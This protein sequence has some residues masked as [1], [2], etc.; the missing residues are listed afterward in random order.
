MKVAI[1]AD[2][3]DNFVK[4]RAEGLNRMLSS[5][6]IPSKVFYQGLQFLDM[7][8]KK[9]EWNLSGPKAALR[10]LIGQVRRP[11]KAFLNRTWRELEN[12]DLMVVVETVPTAFLTYQ[13][14]RVE[15]VRLR[16]PKMP[17][18]LYSSIYLSTM[19][20]WIRFLKHGNDYHGFIKG[21]NHFGLERF[22]WYLIGS[23]ATDFPLP[24]GFQPM[25]EIGCNLDDGSL[26]PAQK[27]GDF[28]AL[29]DFERPNHMPERAIQIMALEKTKTHYQVLNGRYPMARIREIYRS[30]SIYFLAHL[31]AFG[32]PIVEVQACGAKVFT[33]YAKWAWAHYHKTDLTVAGP[34]P[35]SDNFVV[36]DNSLEL[37][38]EKIE[39]V[40]AQ[41]NAERNLN[42]FLEKDGRFFHGDLVKLEQFVAA[43]RTGEIHSGLH[44]TYMPLNDLIVETF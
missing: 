40:K 14:S 8:E 26:Y 6:G 30:T 5:L 34:G 22:D 44:K 31:E 19:G 43:I 32:L 41:F 33:P 38:C 11:D 36:Y 27:P 37:L 7:P 23:A 39:Q 12:F 29:I 10:S 25:T 17:V 13:L 2:T 42:L 28:L 3:A 15:E 9:P 18:V 20:E 1:M 16:F 21:K 24:K 35:L 4:P